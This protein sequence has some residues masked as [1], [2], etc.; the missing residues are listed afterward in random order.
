M[1]L[2]EILASNESAL[3]LLAFSFVLIPS[4][5]EVWHK[6]LYIRDPARKNSQ[7]YLRVEWTSAFKGL[8][9]ILSR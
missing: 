1:L 5:S 2:A 9:L 4:S 6:H 3:C 8:F 7:F